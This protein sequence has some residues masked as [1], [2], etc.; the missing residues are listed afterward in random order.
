VQTLHLHKHDAPQGTLQRLKGEI[1]QETVI[2]EEKTISPP[3]KKYPRS[4]VS[5]AIC[6]YAT[7][8]NKKRKAARKRQK[9][10]RRASRGS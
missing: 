3:Q 2:T 1:M 7:E 6:D 8:R 10:G 5:D 4:W 9:A